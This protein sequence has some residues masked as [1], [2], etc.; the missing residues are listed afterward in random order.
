MNTLAVPATN[1]LPITQIAFEIQGLEE[2]INKYGD[3][4][5]IGSGAFFS[6]YRAKNVPLVIKILNIYQNNICQDLKKP[7][8]INTFMW[9]YYFRV[10]GI[11][12]P[13]L[14]R[15]IEI[16]PLV[17]DGKDS[18]AIVSELGVE[19][20]SIF[21]NRCIPDNFP[22]EEF[23]ACNIWSLLDLFCQLEREELWIPD[24]KPGNILVREDYSLFVGDLDSVVTL[25]PMLKRRLHNSEYYQKQT[26]RIT[27]YY[28]SKELLGLLES[29][30]HNPPLP[31]LKKLLVKNTIETLTIIFTR[32]VNCG[33]ISPGLMALSKHLN[34]QLSFTNNVPTYVGKNYTSVVD[35]ANEVK[36]LF[37]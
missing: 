1:K 23:V 10:M 15:N 27:P 29:T 34:S 32:M 5:P 11:S 17:I 14:P 9:E 31:E 24:L 6:V 30:K 2:V 18:L 13:A 16:L 19:D 12:H 26:W 4:E 28:A 20:L 33:P 22:W 21:L 7:G 37:A 25:N 8:F 3:I 36:S 35:F